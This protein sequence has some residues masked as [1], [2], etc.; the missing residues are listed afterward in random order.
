[1]HFKHQSTIHE[2]RFKITII[3][4]ETLIQH[5]WYYNFGPVPFTFHC[6]CNILTVTYDIK[7]MIKPRP[8]RVFRHQTKSI[9]NYHYLSFW[10]VKTN[11]ITNDDFPSNQCP[12]NLSFEYRLLTV[13]IWIY[14]FTSLLIEFRKNLGKGLNN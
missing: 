9:L 10:F 8:S 2:L 12:Y 13:E 1:M 14:I 3:Y 4:I 7:H 6:S 11:S 5:Q